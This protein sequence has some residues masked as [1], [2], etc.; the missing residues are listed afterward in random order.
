MEPEGHRHGMFK[1][2][3]RPHASKDIEKKKKFNG[4]KSGS[5][6]FFFN[7]IFNILML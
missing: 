2:V 7:L 5:K 3:P 1:R 6:I 4:A